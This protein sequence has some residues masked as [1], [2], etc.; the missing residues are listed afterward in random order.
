VS[1]LAEALSVIVVRDAVQAVYPGGAEGFERD[2]PN[3]TFCAD[4]HLL[5]VGFMN[6]YDVEAFVRGLEAVGLRFSDT[7]PTDICVVDQLTGPTIPCDWLAFERSEGGYS[8]CWL[9]DKPK[10]EMAVPSGWSPE[11]SRGMIFIGGEPAPTPDPFGLE[12]LLQKVRSAEQASRHLSDSDSADDAR[13]AWRAVVERPSES[14]PAQELQA[15]VLDHAGRA[16]HRIYAVSGHESDLDDA[17]NALETSLGCTGAGAEE[18]ADRLDALGRILQD[19]Y[20]LG[21]DWRYLD[22]AIELFE[23]AAGEAQPQ[24][25]DRAMYLNDLGAA[26]SDR[27]VRRGRFARH[28]LERAIAAYDEVLASSGLEA[29]WRE[30]TINNLGVAHR[31]RFLLGGEPN[32]LERAVE[33]GDLALAQTSATDPDLVSRL[34]NLSAALLDRYDNAGEEEDLDRALSLAEH[35]LAVPAQKA[36]D[37]AATDDH[38]AMV[39]LARFV[40]RGQFVDLDR[41]ISLLERA[42]SNTPTG[43]PDQAAGLNNLASARVTRYQHTGRTEDLKRAVEAL[44]AAVTEGPRADPGAPG[45][46]ANLG[47]ALGLAGEPAAEVEACRGALGILAADA[48]EAPGILS[49]LGKALLGVY[50]KDGDGRALDEAVVRCKESLAMTPADAEHDLALH[51]AGLG[52][53]YAARYWRDHDQADLCSARDAFARACNTGLLANLPAALRGAASW[54]AMAMKAGAWDQASEAYGIGML[55]MRVL[56]ATQ[57]LR[58]H[59][60]TWLREAVDLSAA[61]ASAYARCADTRGA[62]IAL[63]GG[64]A[65]LLSEAL[66]LDRV[67]LVELGEQRPD[68]AERYRRAVARW[69]DASRPSLPLQAR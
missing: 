20:W 39:L 9:R 45:R 68:L 56:F 60:E 48:P 47:I 2:C 25:D 22:R 24:S 66:E 29:G 31:R 16:L 37:R 11:N 53:A 3:Q 57:L 46:L 44:T 6:P 63:E 49:S 38:A 54:G 26:L 58:I 13:T 23:E 27:F 64:R 19:R 32:D 18:R 17:A 42:V 5:R 10:G 55:A 50:R 15:M 43:S 33:L 65:V 4:P 34:R 28:D 1:V 59:K 41:A 62:V 36:V 61:A 12:D 40:R 35:A 8:L 67:R 30:A 69:R 21:G 52:D 51:A 7:G 14:F